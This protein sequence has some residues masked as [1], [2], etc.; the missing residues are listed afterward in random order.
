[1]SVLDQPEMMAKNDSLNILGS[2]REFPDQIL[3][4]LEET[5]FLHLP[6]S[7]QG[8][9]RIVFGGM[10]GS[11]LPGE[12]IKSLPGL[13]VPFTVVS[14]YHQPDWLDS[15][16]LVILASYS[17]N[18]EETLSLAREVIKKSSRIIVFTTG[19]ALAAFAAYHHLTVYLP[20]PIHNPSGQPRTS[21]GYFVTALAVVLTRLH[22]LKTNLR[23]FSGIIKDLLTWEKRLASDQPLAVNPAK[24]LAERTEKKT[25]LLISAEHLN[26]TALA[27]RNM[28]HETAKTFATT[29]VVP[30]LNHHLL[31]G[32][33]FP[34]DLGV[35]LTVISF[36]STLYSKVIRRRLQ[37]TQEIFT[38]Q[39][40][41]WITVDL[42]ARTRLED[43]YRLLIFG[44]YFSY[45]LAMLYGVDP[46]PIPKVDY[47][48]I[49]LKK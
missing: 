31:E 44:G 46:G 47:L 15:E 20:K 22:Y 5:G 27:V 14:D 21:L 35:N 32:L 33:S 8:A 11:A 37:V 49:Q 7:L 24:Q 45:Y 17:G 6:V 9:K 13:K 1:M 4:S 40:I 41:E 3:Q 28:I 39:H 48:K 43:V 36:F 29:A 26:G 23:A 10:G 25:L 38:R 2:V 34:A 12:I 18:T 19:E 42:S 16:T 30:D